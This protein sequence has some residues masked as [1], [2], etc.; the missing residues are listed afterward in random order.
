MTDTSTPLHRNRWVHLA[1]GIAV[2]VACLAWAAG[3]L[4]RDKDAIEQVGT[5]FVQA[6]Y[7][8]LPPMWGALVGFYLIKAWRW[9]LLLKPVGDYHTLRDLVPPTMTGFAFNNLLP[10]HLGDFVRVYL[11]ARKFRAP[12]TAVLSTVVLERVFDIVAILLLLGTGLVFVEL[13]DPNVRRAALVFAAAAGAF[14]IVA[15]AYVIWTR[16]F[17]AIFEAVLARLP[18]VPAGLRRKLATMLEAGAAGLASLKHPQL[19]AGIAVSSLAQWILNGSMVYLALWSFGIQVG[20]GLLVSCIVLGVTALAVAIPS[21]PGYFG[22][23][24]AA[25][26]SVLALFGANQADVFAASIYFHL[27]QYIPVTL[28][29]LYYFNTT[30][31]TFAEVEAAAETETPLAAGDDRTSVGSTPPKSLSTTST[32]ADSVTSTE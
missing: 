29:G 21:S 19:L 16:R 27:A 17:V 32:P 8:T 26:M 2:S 30:G 22:V 11:F 12:V 13:P 28:V 23:I 31:L 4:L 10:A 15:L 14:V 25:F 3:G 9:R 7:L 6:N 5:A 24:Q 18:L 20:N 1:L